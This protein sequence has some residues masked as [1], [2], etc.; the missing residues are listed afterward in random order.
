MTPGAKMM[1][2]GSTIND[3]I[4]VQAPTGSSID[5]DMTISGKYPCN[6][7]SSSVPC[8]FPI[9]WLHAVI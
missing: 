3:V 9:F 5:D 1:V 2:I 4:T 6:F 8:L 7:D